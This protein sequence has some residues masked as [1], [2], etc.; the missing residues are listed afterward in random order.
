MLPTPASM[1][2]YLDGQ[3]GTQN[4]FSHTTHTTPI[5]NFPPLSN[6]NVFVGTP[7]EQPKIAQIPTPNP[8]W[9]N[10]QRMVQK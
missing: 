7:Q 2:T 10:M 9:D 4:V 6:A 3:A 8:E 5:G 1:P